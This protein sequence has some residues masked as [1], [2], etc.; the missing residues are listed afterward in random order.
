MDNMDNNVNSVKQTS[1][2]TIFLKPLLF[3]ALGVLVSSVFFYLNPFEN[4]KQSKFSLTS[5]SYPENSSFT[6][7]PLLSN[8]GLQSGIDAAI[9]QDGDF[10]NIRTVGAIQGIIKDINYLSSQSAVVRV[11]TQNHGEI[12]INVDISG[13]K[14]QKPIFDQRIGQEVDLE[15]LEKSR[16]AIFNFSCQPKLKDNQ[17]PIMRILGVFMR[18]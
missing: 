3:M 9:D 15:G 1:I 12:S 13:P 10:T 2:F 17:T 14:Y 7:L 11:E 16:Q 8:C 5:T 4:P 6:P 18:A